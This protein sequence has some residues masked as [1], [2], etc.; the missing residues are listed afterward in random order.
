[1]EGN[2]WFSIRFEQETKKRKQQSNP[3]Q[4]IRWKKGRGR[5][6][7]KLKGENPLMSVLLNPISDRESVLFS[8][9]LE[10]VQPQTLPNRQWFLVDYKSR[11]WRE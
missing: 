6:Q 10:F 11:A 3:P 7:L 1:M 5:N 9:Y 4:Q 2:S 8:Y